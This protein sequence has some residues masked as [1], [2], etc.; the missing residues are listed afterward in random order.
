MIK[1]LS[2]N[3]FFKAMQLPNE[4]SFDIKCRPIINDKKNDLQY[5]TCL[6][7]VAEFINAYGPYDFVGLQEA[8]NWRIIQKITPVLQQHMMSAVS[9]CE[10]IDEI[11]T[12]YD[13][14]KYELDDTNNVLKGH[15]AD[16]NRPFIMLF[17]KHKLCVIN[18]HAGHYTYDKGSRVKD[19]YRLNYYLEQTLIKN[20]FG[21]I[22]VEKLISYDIIMMGDFN[23]ELRNIN[24]FRLLGRKL[25]GINRKATCCDVNLAANNQ[26]GAFDHVLSNFSRSKNIVIQDVTHASDHLP[27]ISVLSTKKFNPLKPLNIGYDF[28]GVLHMSVTP[29]D[30]S[31]QR[32]PISLSGP[33]QVFDKIINQIY[34]EIIDGHRIYIITARSETKTSIDAINKHLMKTKLSPYMDQITIL[35]SKG[36][37][38]VSLLNKFGINTFYDDSCLRIIELYDAKK[39]GL[40]PSLEDIYFVNPDNQTITLINQQT[41]KKYCLSNK[42]NEVASDLD[43]KDNISICVNIINKLI[44]KH[45]YRFQN[46]QI[47]VLLGKLKNGIS[48]GEISLGQCTQ[49]QSDIIKLINEDLHYNK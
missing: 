33:F 49:L 32:H 39:N 24:E 5:S 34:E 13:N 25:Y 27:I 11:V 9:H 29:A 16:I 42:L 21:N 19:I 6:K 28:D 47:N 23:D 35:F 44:I 45:Q 4:K 2:Y 10:G 37:S 41:I 8:T 43:N 46:P 17:F 18:L 40:L 12:F 15:M 20:K 48:K 1:V 38:K 31:G 22:Y 14:N 26:R 36:D 30:T 3:I 7:N